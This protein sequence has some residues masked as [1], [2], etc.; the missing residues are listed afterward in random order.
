M[1]KPLKIKGHKLSI[2]RSGA[3]NGYFSGRCECGEWHSRNWVDNARSI[4]ISHQSHLRKVLETTP[5]A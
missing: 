2:E 5:A 4:R 1:N 3:E